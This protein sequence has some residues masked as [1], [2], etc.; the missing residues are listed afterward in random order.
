MAGKAVLTLLSLLVG[1][2][3]ALTGQIYQTGA[4]T[5]E[6]FAW[7]AVADPAL[8]GGRPLRSALAALARPAQPRGLALFL[9]G[10]GRR[11]PDVESARPQ[12]P[13]PG[14]LGGGA[15]GGDRLAS[16]RLAAAAGG[17]R[18]RG[19]GDRPRLVGDR[20]RRARAARA[21]FAWIGLALFLVP[22]RPARPVHAGRRP[23]QPDRRRRRLPVALHARERRR[24]SVH[25]PRRDR[26]VGR[27][28]DLAQSVAREPGA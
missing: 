17:D 28:R 20:R 22:A 1:A 13:R 8:G 2:L 25:R 7:W 21:G 26:H 23:A 9:A 16:R 3:L 14:R 10:G 15:P 4:D 11:D 6:L 27:R 19:H 12:R 18:Q 5:Y 24:L